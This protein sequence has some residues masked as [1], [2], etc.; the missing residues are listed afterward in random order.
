[1]CASNEV[2]P[3]GVGTTLGFVVGLVLGFFVGTYWTTVL[4]AVLIGA[5]SGIVANVLA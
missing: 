4:Y 1:M 3:S 5:G 2:Q